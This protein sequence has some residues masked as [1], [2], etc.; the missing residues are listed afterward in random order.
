MCGLVG[1]AGDTSIK[2]KDAFR[3]ML[4]VCQVRGR[5]STGVFTVNGSEYDLAK[6]LG[7]PEILMDRKSF[8]STLFGCPRIMAGHCR[9]K[10]VGDNTVGNAHPYDLDNIIGMHNGTLKGHHQWNEFNYKITDSLALFTRIDTLGLEETFNDLDPTGAWALVWYNKLD[11]TLNF[12]RNDQR[13]LWLTWTKDKRNLIWASETWFFGAVYRKE[14]LWDGTLD[15][16]EKVSPYWSLPPNQLFSFSVNDKA[17]KG[18]KVHTLHPIRN[19]EAKKAITVGF[20]GH[21]GGVKRWQE[22]SASNEGGEVTSPFLLDDEVTDIGRMSAGLPLLPAPLKENPAQTPGESTTTGGTQ[23]PSTTTSSPVMDFRPESMRGKNSLQRTLSL[24]TTT[25]HSSP[26]T[27]NVVNLSELRKSYTT[28]GSRVSLRRPILKGTWYISCKK[29]S[30]E[31]SEKDFEDNTGA[32][33]SACKKPIGDLKE[34][35]EFLDPKRFV[36]LSCLT[37]PAAEVVFKKKSKK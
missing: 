35:G 17:G 16:G 4:T 37:E 12:L 11:D 27:N 9:S 30:Q 20:H 24:R 18:E 25:S 33:C 14:E 21:G 28:P 6:S 26:Q 8:D 15:D 31:W 3:D 32:V 19:I 29:T 34:V 1:I 23:G 7:P 13:P 2:L 10:T 22:T 36:C 5:D